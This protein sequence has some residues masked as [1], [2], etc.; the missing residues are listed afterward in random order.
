[1]S[2]HEDVSGKGAAE[3]TSK[4]ERQVSQDSLLSTVESSDVVLYGLN[5][6]VVGSC[7]TPPDCQIL[8]L[9]FLD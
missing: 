1:M 6:V 4:D 7:Y 3:E 2:D 8:S 5:V 9:E